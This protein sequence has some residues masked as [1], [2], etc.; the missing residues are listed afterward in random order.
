MKARYIR[1]SS[2]SQ[3]QERQ[4]ARSDTDEKVY[5]DTISGS[6]PFNER[7]QAKE[8]IKDCEKKK[9][10]SISVSSVDRLGRDAFDI[11]KTIE[12]FNT[13][14]INIT[15]DNLGIQSIIDGKTNPIFKMITD[16]LAN[17]A[18]MEKDSI[19]ERQLE[20]IAIAKKNGTYKGRE[21]GSKETPEQILKKYPKV[22]KEIKLYPDS[23]LRRLA[24]YSQVSSNTVKKVKKIL[25][26]YEKNRR[27]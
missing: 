22:V 25:E 14:C 26:E 20:G 21:K 15:I 16:V 6:T 3:S 8:L 4:L 18:Q 17:V 2:S 13:K 5:T 10:R 11:Q 1:T 23:S 27:T 19:R 12:Y 9:I 7:T 24:R